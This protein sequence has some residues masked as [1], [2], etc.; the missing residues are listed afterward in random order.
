M[1]AINIMEDGKIIV[2]WLQPVKSNPKIVYSLTKITY[3][4]EREIFEVLSS[5]YLHTLPNMV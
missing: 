1:V 4:N 3:L 5:F 2:D